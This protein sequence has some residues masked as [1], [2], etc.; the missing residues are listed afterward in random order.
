MRLDRLLRSTC[1]G[2]W[3]HLPLGRS[4]L[5]LPRPVLEGGGQVMGAGGDSV[6]QSA[7]E[8][9]KLLSAFAVKPT[10]YFYTGFNSVGWGRMGQRWK[11]LRV[12]ARSGC[13]KPFVSVKKST[14]LKTESQHRHPRMF[15]AWGLEVMIFLAFFFS[16]LLQIIFT[17]VLVHI[18]MLLNTWPQMVSHS[19]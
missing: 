2:S 14:L 19:G 10:K 8:T 18:L 12:P 4:R 17:F 13:N 16:G 3:P 6:E 1:R 11:R 9:F 5:V 7:S 15:L